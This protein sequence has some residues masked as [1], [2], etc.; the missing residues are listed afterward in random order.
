MTVKHL[1]TT[2]C[3]ACRGP[4]H[5][6]GCRQGRAGARRG[7][8]CPQ[9]GQ[10]GHGS[11]YFSLDLPRTTGGG[12]AGSAGAGT[13]PGRRPSRRWNSCRCPAAGCLTVAEWLVTWLETRARLRENTRRGYAAH[14]H[15]YLTPHLGTVLLA[16]LHIGHLE[17]V[18]T[19]R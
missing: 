16:E 5:D 13:R 17:Q 3:Q 1:P 4:L 19:A 11:W 12:G 6:S 18:F 9:L 15:R 10:Q 7:A 14:I 8:S 2:K